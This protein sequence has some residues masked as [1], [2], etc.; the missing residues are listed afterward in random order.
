MVGRR[1]DVSVG[2]LMF[3][4]STLSVLKKK[5]KKKKKKQQGPDW[6]RHVINV[7]AGWKAGTEAVRRSVKRQKQ[8]SPQRA[9]AGWKGCVDWDRKTHAC[10]RVAGKRRSV[11]EADFVTERVNLCDQFKRN[12][13]YGVIYGRN[14]TWTG[15]GSLRDIFYVQRCDERCSSS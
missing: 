2:A 13:S 3:L 6:V 11:A 15:K 5:K 1:L 4:S 9:C 8:R 12:D 7:W 10:R 14:V